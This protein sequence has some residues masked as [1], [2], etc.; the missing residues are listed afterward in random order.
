MMMSKSLGFKTLVPGWPL[1]IFRIAFGLLY[2]DFA[3]QKAPWNNFGW[4]Q[5]WIEKEIATPAFP[6]M[7]RS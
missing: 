4:L 5:G 6:G 7:R 3:L 1:A 2:L